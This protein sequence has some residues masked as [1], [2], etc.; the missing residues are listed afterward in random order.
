MDILFEVSAKGMDGKKDTGKKSLSFSP[1]FDDICCYQGN[2]VH[3]IAVKPEEC[4]EFRRHSK[5]DVLPGSSGKGV[6]AV[7]DPEV[8]GLFTAGGAESGFATVWNFD[9]LRAGRTDKVMVTE[10]RSSAHKEF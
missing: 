6:K 9:A 8:S 1:L 10:K 5:G 4:P 7:F 2:K 3:K